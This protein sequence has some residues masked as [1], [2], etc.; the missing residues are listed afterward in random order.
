MCARARENN[1]GTLLT[2]DAITLVLLLLASCS[3]VFGLWYCRYHLGL[4]C[5]GWWR[6]AGFA[7]LGP[8][9]LL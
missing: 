3:L 2:H 6:P 8:Q 9:D 4:W 5:D 7:L 1:I